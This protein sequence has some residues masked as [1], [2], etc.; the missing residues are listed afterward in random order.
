MPVTNQG[1][2]GPLSCQSLCSCGA[3]QGP[4]SAGT[5]IDVTPVSTIPAGSRRPSQ[6]LK[7]SGLLTALSEFP[8]RLQ[9]SLLLHIS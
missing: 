3:N 4:V 1:R 5:A 7:I 8:G 2:E 9:K 6:K